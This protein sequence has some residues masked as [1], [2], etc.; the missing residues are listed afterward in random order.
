MPDTVESDRRS[1]PRAR[2]DL[3]VSINIDN[4]PVLPVTALNLSASGI[5]CNSRDKLGELTRV[6]LVLRLDDEYVIPARAVV[7]REEKLSDGSFGLGMFFTSI[8]DEHRALIAEL[9]SG[10]RMGDRS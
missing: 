2:V 3:G 5:Y 10:T 6:D 7:I 8:L 4:M 9:V 1:S